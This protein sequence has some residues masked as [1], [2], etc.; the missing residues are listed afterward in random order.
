MFEKWTFF[1]YFKILNRRWGYWEKLQLLS[2][3]SQIVSVPPQGHLYINASR[4]KV[5]KHEFIRTA[6]FSNF[7]GKV[8][9]LVLSPIPMVLNAGRWSSFDS[10]ISFSWLNYSHQIWQYFNRAS[11]PD[12]GWRF[13]YSFIF[14][15]IYP[16]YMKKAANRTII[17]PYFIKF[18][19]EK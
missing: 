7:Q 9:F 13:I 14:C 19:L 16:G 3:F 12:L 17:L 5:Q 2:S 4:L 15:S 18:A 6:L 10:S 11:R 8:L 1:L